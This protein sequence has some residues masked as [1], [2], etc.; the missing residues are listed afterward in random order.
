M[1]PLSLPLPPVYAVSRDSRGCWSVYA[2][3]RCEL[4]RRGVRRIARLPPFDEE[5]PRAATP[6]D[7]RYSADQEMTTC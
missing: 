4:S 5:R 7:L 3:V 6:A 1:P 2:P